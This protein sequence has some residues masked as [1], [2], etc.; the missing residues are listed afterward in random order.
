MIEHHFQP[1]FTHFIRQ[2]EVFQHW[3]KDGVSKLLDLAG[4]F[5]ADFTQED[6]KMSVEIGNFKTFLF[7][8]SYNKAN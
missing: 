7:S 2:K 8:F 6:N 5:S 1:D 3:E 4:D